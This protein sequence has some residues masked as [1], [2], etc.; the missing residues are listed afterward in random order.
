MPRSRLPL[1]TLP[2]FRAAAQSQNLRATAESLH[3]THSAVSQQI[4]LLE[5]QLG[6]A[7]FDRR[8]R[9]IV[10]NAAGQALLRSV[11]PALAQLDDGVQAASAA[12]AGTEQRMRI[13]VLPSFAQRW[14]LPRMGRWRERHPDI[15]IEIHASQQ[16]MDL[17]RDGFHAAVRQG[18]GGWPGLVCE[19][20]I[21]SPL[22]PVGSPAAARRLLGLGAQALAHEPLLG[23][24]AMW[25]RWFA[26]AGV[27]V[28]VNPV[29][30]FND[31][32][33]MLQATEQNLGIAL[34]RELLAA[35]ALCDGR[36][37][38]LSSQTLPDDGNDIYFLAYPT[39]VEHWPPLQAL[40]RWLLDELEDRR[41]D[42]DAARR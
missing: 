40:R 28:R 42:L 36:L 7:L 38:R 17:Q 34:V 30:A 32:G 5:E 3:L 6:F 18:R 31:A 13:T 19:R 20:L 35:D 12:A 26:A 15:A 9:R 16:L 21:D 11:E 24:A 23:N 39:G 8:G 29:A 41:Q 10:L 27:R 14:L 33:L 22:I 25:E 1:Q 4:R 37:M 2:V